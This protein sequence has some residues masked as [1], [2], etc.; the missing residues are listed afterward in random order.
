[1]NTDL[2][3]KNPSR[4]VLYGVSWCPDC[5]RA[6]AVLNRLGV[7]YLDVD[8]D[9]DPQAAAFITELNNGMRRVPT[10][11][12]PDGSLLVEPDNQTLTLH[13]QPYLA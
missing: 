12:F 8:V 11:V 1:M 3:Q 13:L 10:I 2:Y 4:I 6:R 5:H 7:S 9:N